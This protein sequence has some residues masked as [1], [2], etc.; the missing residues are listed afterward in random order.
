MRVPLHVLLIWCLLL[1]PPF[2]LAQGKGNVPLTV[3]SDRDCELTLDGRSNG[4][5]TSGGITVT[6][7]VG[8]HIVRCET[9]SGQISLYT[10]GDVSVKGPR[11]IVLREFGSHDTE[12]LIA[13]AF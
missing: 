12:A 1:W 7:T 3:K 11:D 6:V 8:Y 5:V 13:V 2:L 4:N 10:E 9:K